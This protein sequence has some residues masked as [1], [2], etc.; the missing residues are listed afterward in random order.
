MGDIIRRR[1]DQQPIGTVE[2]LR[3]FLERHR[4]P[5]Q[6]ILQRAVLMVADGVS[7]QRFGR[8]GWSIHENGK[9][10]D[11]LGISAVPLEPHGEAE[12]AV[13]MR[14]HLSLERRPGV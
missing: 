14:Q 4:H 10:H 11:I 1:A 3:R 13:G 7:C 6:P 9:A 8:R 12:E 5:D 2:A